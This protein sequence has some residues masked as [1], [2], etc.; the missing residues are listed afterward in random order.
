MRH[1][2]VREGFGALQAALHERRFPRFV[3][4]EFEAYLSWG[5]PEYGF[6]WLTCAECQTHRIVPFS[7][8]K[9][10]FCPA[11][12]GRRMAVMAVTAAKWADEMLPRVAVRQWALTVPWERR[13]L[14]G[15]PDRHVGQG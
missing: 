8:K 2:V 13:G 4:R 10:G 11:C 9:R 3:G 1:E 6:A 7:C 15:P 12:R 5:D 14:F